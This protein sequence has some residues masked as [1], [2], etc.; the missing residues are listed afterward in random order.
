MV[1]THYQPSTFIQK[2]RNTEIHK[3]E[4]KT[5]AKQNKN[6]FSS[7]LEAAALHLCAAAE[8]DEVERARWVNIEVFQLSPESIK[9]HII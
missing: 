8:P 6:N 7:V 3:R 1:R 9:L 5:I 2:R 4:Q